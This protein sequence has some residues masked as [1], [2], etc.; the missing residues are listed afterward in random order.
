MENKVPI[1]VFIFLVAV[2]V[3]FS[4]VFAFRYFRGDAL[5]DT[6]TTK[7]TEVSSP[8]IP[9]MSLVGMCSY[10]ISPSGIVYIKSHDQYGDSYTPFITEYGHYV[11]YK[12]GKYFIVGYDG[13]AGE[14]TL[15]EFPAFPYEK[16]EE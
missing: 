7:A 2:C 9:R 3:A 15:P 14:Y 6:V 11:V 5:D 16:G 10:A 1:G 8:E 12:D 13:A 4:V